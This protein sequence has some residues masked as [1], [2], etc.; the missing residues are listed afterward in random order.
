MFWMCTSHPYDPKM[1]ETTRNKI[2]KSVAKMLQRNP[3]Q[4]KQILYE[5]C[6]QM[7]DI[8]DPDDSSIADLF[9]DDAVTP[10]SEIDDDT[11]R[12]CDDRPRKAIV[13]NSTQAKLYMSDPCIF[14]SG[15][16]S[17]KASSIKIYP[18]TTVN[19]SATNLISFA[20]FFTDKLYRQNSEDQWLTWQGVCIDSGAQK[21]VIG[22]S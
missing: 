6:T 9:L 21:T 2:I 7:E 14:Y 13:V 19:L 22:L 20:Y 3:R 15:Y 18:P 17:R 1:F 5:L 11:V 12:K 8:F 10:E 4:S 16:T